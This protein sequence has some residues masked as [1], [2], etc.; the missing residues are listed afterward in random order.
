L[1]DSTKLLTLTVDEAI[2]VHYCEGKATS[3]EDIL[4]ANNMSDYPVTRHVLTPLEKV[5]H[6]LINPYLQSILIMLMIG[7]IYFEFQTPGIGFALV[8]SIIAALLYFSP[9]FIEGIASHWELALFIVGLLLIGLEIFAL[10]GFGV[11]GI[12]G[13][14]LVV[15]GITLAMV[16]NIVFEWNWAYGLAAVFKSLCMVVV[17]AVTALGLSIWAG[18]YFFGNNALSRIMLKTEQKSAEGYVSFDDL[19]NLVGVIG[20]ARS[21]LRPA[22]KVDI[23]GKLFDAVSEI[24]FINAGETVKIIRFETGQLHVIRINR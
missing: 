6:F 2:S 14:I 7:G 18:Q 22:G 15:L 21:V 10:P 1:V 9:L 24:G 8:V 4:V 16:D 19:S 13:I 20:I 3:I 23:D 17:S 5:I 11:A 12:T